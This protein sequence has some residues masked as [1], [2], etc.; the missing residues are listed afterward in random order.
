[1]PDIDFTLSQKG[2]FLPP[3]NDSKSKQEIKKKG[4]RERENTN[5]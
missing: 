4:E 3:E 5:V 2:N 1:M